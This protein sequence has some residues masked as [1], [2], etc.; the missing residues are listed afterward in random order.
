MA[1]RT[2][3]ESNP[4]TPNEN[5]IYH[6]VS[7]TLVFITKMIGVLTAVMMVITFIL[8]VVRGSINDSY[9]L[10]ATNIVIS[11]IVG[12]TVSWWYRNGDLSSD[13]TWF[14]IVVAAVITF[15]CITSD[16]YVFHET[17]VAPTTSPIP[18]T[19]RFTLIPLNTTRPRFQLNNPLTTPSP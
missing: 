12:L 15:Q 9:Y 10:L 19:T 1:D 5:A 7:P 2:R 17:P 3:A 13:K 16:I 8:C 14:L 6:E 4:T 18:N 11:A